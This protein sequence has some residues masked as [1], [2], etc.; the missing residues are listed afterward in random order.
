MLWNGILLLSISFFPQVLNMLDARFTKGF[1]ESA[2][3][4]VVSL[5]L[6]F[7]FIFKRKLTQKRMLQ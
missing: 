7:P 1:V 3:L 4:E 2:L 6:Y 5:F